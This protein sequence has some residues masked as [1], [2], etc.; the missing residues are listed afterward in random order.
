VTNARSRQARLAQLLSDRALEGLSEQEAQELAALLEGREDDSFDRAAAAVAL[1]TMDR[2]EP[3]P[4][5][6][7]A[8]IGA[9]AQSLLP[10]GATSPKDLRLQSAM[11]PIALRPPRDP[12]RFAGW[13]AAAACLLLAIG[14]G[15][16]RTGP[17][18]RAV[19]RQAP[20]TS[21]APGP[22]PLAA[23]VEAPAP[24]PSPS[25]QREEL[26]TA[27]DA[28]RVE[29]STTKDPAGRGASGD[30]VWSGSQ[31][32]GF[33]RFRGLAANDPSKSQ[34]QLWIFDPSQDKKTPIDGGVFDVDPATGDVVVPIVAKLHVTGPTLFAVTVEKPGGVVVSKRKRIVL[35]AAVRA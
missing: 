34:Y 27:T 1:L 22:A 17:A 16:G 14:P 32:R 19:V 3:L 13:V 18:L 30:V 10:A 35:T 8:S 33:M 24:P 21:S 2:A 25:A 28:L 4:P 31:Q 6:L 11:R 9:A 5:H 15:F 26:L 29:W 20:S 7:S 12:L 23:S